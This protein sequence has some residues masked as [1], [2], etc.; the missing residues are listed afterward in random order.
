MSVHFFGLTL[1]AY[2]WI[3]C[4]RLVLG[5]RSKL[6]HSDNLHRCSIVLEIGNCKKYKLVWKVCSVS[7]CQSISWCVRPSN[8]LSVCLN[9]SLVSCIS[10]RVIDVA[11]ALDLLVC[12]FNI[13]AMTS[14]T[15]W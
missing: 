13:C 10:L 14:C 12:I 7:V 1:V 6:G 8:C 2:S 3:L 5:Q 15:R 4:D 11:P 9:W